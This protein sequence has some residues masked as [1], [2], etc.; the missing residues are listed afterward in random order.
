MS[1]NITKL[2]NKIE[3]FLFFYLTHLG[4]YIFNEA[5]WS[6]VDEIGL[7]WINQVLLCSEEAQTIPLIQKGVLLFPPG[8]VT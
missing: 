4:D 7:D 1:I 5:K 3:Y 6:D 2:L 8:F